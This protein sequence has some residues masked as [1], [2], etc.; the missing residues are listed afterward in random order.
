MKF[1]NR[2]ILLVGGIFFLSFSCLKAQDVQ[3]SGDQIIGK[4]ILKSAIYNG[5]SISLADVTNHISFEFTSNGGVTFSNFNGKVENGAFLVKENKLID[6]KVPESLSADI[7]SLSK[8]RLIL[9]MNEDRNEVLM[10]FELQEL[11]QE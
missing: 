5:K 7:V 11:K 2:L 6:P 10:M 8:N 9:S 1:K 4:W 3:Y